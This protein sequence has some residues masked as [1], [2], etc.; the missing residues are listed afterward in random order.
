[1][2]LENITT[3]DAKTHLS[4]LLEKV[5]D[6]KGYVITKRGKP[7]AKLT[8]YTEKFGNTD[9][10]ILV[11]EILAFRKLRTL[12]DGCSIDTLKKEGRR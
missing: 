12:G 6:G 7:V 8:G 10:K 11:K 5:Q 4:S 9:Q 1:M 3:F 2:D